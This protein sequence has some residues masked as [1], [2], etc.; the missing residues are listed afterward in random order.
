MT[1]NQHK[2]DY[3]VYDKKS[4]RNTRSVGLLFLPTHVPACRCLLY[5][6]YTRLQG[7]TQFLKFTNV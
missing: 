6:D 1:I 5:R 3:L 2:S 7:P 4:S